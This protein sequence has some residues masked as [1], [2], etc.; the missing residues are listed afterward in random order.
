MVKVPAAARARKTIVGASCT[1]R[2]AGASAL[3]AADV[4]ARGEA[5]MLREERR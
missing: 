1:S 5:E 4:E 2:R 3:L